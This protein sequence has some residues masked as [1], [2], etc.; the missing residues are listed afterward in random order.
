M[1]YQQDDSDNTYPHPDDFY[2][3]SHF[4]H[5]ISLLLMRKGGLLGATF[6]NPPPELL[7]RFL[8]VVA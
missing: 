4:V 5:F 1:G 6:L 3:K 8:F 2:F 7:G